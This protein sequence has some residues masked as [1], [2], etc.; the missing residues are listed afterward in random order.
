MEDR[1]GTHEGDQVGALTARQR[2]YAASI[3][4]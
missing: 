3:S 1:S 2:D 4:L